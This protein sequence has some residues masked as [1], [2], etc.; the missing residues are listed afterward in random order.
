[1]NVVHLIYPFFLVINMRVIV[2]LP[3]DSGTFRVLAEL[4]ILSP[5]REDQ[6]HNGGN[7]MRME[8]VER[9]TRHSTRLSRLFASRAWRRAEANIMNNPIWTLWS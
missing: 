7:V 6:S 8:P 2:Y 5:F 3:Y 4:D 9:G 1:M